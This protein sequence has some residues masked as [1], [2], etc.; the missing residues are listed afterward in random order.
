MLYFKIFIHID[1]RDLSP[2]LTFCC[3]IEYP[4]YQLSRSNFRELEGYSSAKIFKPINHPNLDI[5]MDR[6]RYEISCNPVTVEKC[7]RLIFV[8]TFGGKGI[9][10]LDGQ[11]IH[12]TVSCSTLTP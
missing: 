5:D 11:G 4:P 3:I 2:P 7:S 8:W 10:F 6:Y 9:N 12:L 1:A